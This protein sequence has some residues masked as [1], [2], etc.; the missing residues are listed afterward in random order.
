MARTCLSQTQTAIV[1]PTKSETTPPTPPRDPEITRCSV[2]H[3]ISDYMR[4]HDSDLDHNSHGT[5]RGC[6]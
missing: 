5:R 3:Q 4:V 6:K 1:G 2:F